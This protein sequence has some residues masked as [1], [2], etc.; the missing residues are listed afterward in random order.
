VAPV[1]GQIV[2]GGRPRPKQNRDVEQAELKSK[3]V[4]VAFI[5]V[6]LVTISLGALF[7]FAQPAVGA[8]DWHFGLIVGTYALSI[9]YAFILRFRSAVLA[10]AYVQI[11]LDTTLVT[12]LVALTGGIESVFTFVY[13]FTVLG[14]SITL[15][16]G[17]ATVAAICYFI[18]FGT[19]VLVQVDDRVR[20]LPTVE[21][22]HAIFA[23]FM[24]SVGVALAAGLSSKLA[25]KALIT[26]QMLAERESDYEELEQ[27]QAAIL[28]SLPAGLMTIESDDV[29]RYANE[30]ALAILGLESGDVIAKPLETIVPIMAKR[31]RTLWQHESGLG[32]RE[33]FEE[34][35]RRRDGRSIRLGFSF[36]PL[37]EARSRGSIIVFQDVTEI[38]RLKDAYARA[39]KL[40]TVGKLA[41]GLAHE[42]RNPLA[43]MCA[44]IDVIKNSLQP[45]EPMKRL[46]SNVLSEA[47]R[48]NALIRDFLAFAR[49][50]EPQREICDVSQL[51]ASIMEVFKNDHSLASTKLE[52]HLEE[53]LLASIDPNQMRQVVWNVAKNAA[54]SM[55]GQSDGRLEVSTRRLRRNA[56]IVIRDSGPGI[57]PDQLGRVF[58]PFFTTKEAGSGL[59]LAISHSIV[60]AHGG[61]ILLESKAGEGTEVT[62]SLE[63]AKVP[64]AQHSADIL[65][66]DTS[67]DLELLGAGL[68]PT[69]KM[70]HGL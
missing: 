53:N 31:H 16:R 54:E 44:S 21:F 52:V 56:E 3:L 47:D 12:V 40:A 20:W 37:G 25:E 1:D 46:M 28:R 35:F 51:V 61:R 62:I 7:M 45:P 13:V 39:E 10:L 42:L 65:P 32:A 23:L 22:G 48:L 14:A 43:S 69:A 2:A 64:D 63:A 18:M 29:V 36:A 34:T 67:T 58:D 8:M 66:V 50:R 38:V 68:E 30:S 26:G 70:R 11:F 19:L 59:G 24:Y 60:E 27:L 6:L 55:S 4:V 15:Y 33:R 41:A 9:I 49:P 17:G 57:S 5:R